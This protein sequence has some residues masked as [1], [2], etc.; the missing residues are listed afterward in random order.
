MIVAATLLLTISPRYAVNKSMSNPITVDGIVKRLEL[1]V[2][3]PRFFN[4]NVK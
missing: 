3:N 1:V 2:E 4:D